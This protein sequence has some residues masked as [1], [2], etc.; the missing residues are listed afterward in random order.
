MK[1]AVQFYSEGEK[2]VGDLYVPDKMEKRQPCPAVI[3]CH[4]FAGIKELLLPVYAERLAQHQPAC[5]AE[6]DG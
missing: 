5:S 3:L 1:Q 6:T 2:I 4:G